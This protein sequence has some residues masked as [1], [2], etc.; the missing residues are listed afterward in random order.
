MIG[1]DLFAGAGGMSLGAEMAGTDVQIVIESDPYAAQTYTQNFTPKYDVFNSDIRHYKK[2]PLHIKG[3]PLVVFGGPPCQGFST[4][5]QRTRGKDNP[6][7]WLFREYIRVLKMYKPDWFVF[8]NVSGIL[9][10]ENRFF[11]DHI[12][13]RFKKLGYATSHNIMNAMNFGV[14]QNRSRFFIVGSLNGTSYKFPSPTSIKAV[15]VKQAISDLP[16]LSNGAK[17]DWLEYCKPARSIYSKLMRKKSH[18]CSNHL[19]TN[20]AEYVLERYDHIQQGENWEAIPEYLMKNY[21]DR[22]RCHTGIYR[23]LCDDKP[24]V[25]IGN[26][27]KNMLIHPTKNRG[28]SVR[29]AARLQSFPDWFDFK[30]SIGFKQQQVGNAVPPLL[31]KAIFKQL[32]KQT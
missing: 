26:Y 6:E 8:E 27:R 3:K 2:Q 11:V 21:K 32:I 4:S 25:V 14:P 23:R 31:A 12:L 18:K 1:I 29:E 10:T 20:N 19:V 9:E 28:L 15:T 17:V 5:N 30:G 13:K 7:N 24:S 16:D 22:S